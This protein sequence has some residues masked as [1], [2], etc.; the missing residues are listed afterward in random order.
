MW[1]CDDEE[2][3]GPECYSAYECGNQACLAG[4]C[5]PC[6][7]DDE[8]VFGLVCRGGLC[9]E[10]LVNRVGSGE[11]CG[12]NIDGF[13]R[14]ECNNNLS[15]HPFLNTCISERDEYRL[16]CA[17]TFESCGRPA[18]YDNALDCAE[19]IMAEEVHQIFYL[20]NG[21]CARE[22]SIGDSVCLEECWMFSGD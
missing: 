17:C 2:K 22:G 12:E 19:K 11:D 15:C 21:R 6:T 4:S 8:C 7:R 3:E 1:G 10:P 16:C 13:D 9:E 18:E 5:G 14:V 20:R